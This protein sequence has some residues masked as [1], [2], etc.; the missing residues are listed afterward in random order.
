[1]KIRLVLLALA[2]LMPLAA[3]A[4]A[5]EEAT[6]LARWQKDHTE[7]LQATE[8]GLADVHWLARPVVVFADSDA[9]PRFQQ[10]MD[11]LMA[12]LDDLAL[13]DVVVITDTNPAT[14]S[15]WRTKLRPRGFMLVL[16]AK[17]GNVLFR[18][19]FPWDVREIS[20]SIDK[21]PLR[22]QEIRDRRD[23]A[24]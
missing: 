12:R 10:Q 22:E 16:I 13:R 9:D 3:P 6:P 4:R 24:Q 21:L 7:I 5:A 11:L 1:M 18:K 19:P 8:V 23:A 17:D 20:R 15:E 2:M 14:P